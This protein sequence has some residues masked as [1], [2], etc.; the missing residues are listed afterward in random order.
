MACEEQQKFN[1]LLGNDRCSVQM[2]ARL[3]NTVMLVTD[4]FQ[5]TCNGNE[6]PRAMRSI[7]PGSIQTPGS[8]GGFHNTVCV[9]FV[10]V[11]CYSQLCLLDTGAAGADGTPILSISGYTDCLQVL[12]NRSLY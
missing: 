12:S 2:E 6:S 8:S 4:S 3:S 5:K 9:L 1:I 10:P 7:R 11:G